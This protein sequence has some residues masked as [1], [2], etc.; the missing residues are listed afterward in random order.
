MNKN[1]DNKKNS[2]KE[3]PLSEDKSQN[4]Q[5]K[6]VIA[7]EKSVKKNNDSNAANSKKQ[8]S[9]RDKS[10]SMPSK[11]EKVKLEKHKPAAENSLKND[12][13]QVE[14]KKVEG[15][16]SDTPKNNKKKPTK[17]KGSKNTDTVLAESN[18][19]SLARTEQLK[20]QFAQNP[21]AALTQINR[22]LQNENSSTGIVNVQKVANQALAENKIVL[23]NRFVLESVL[24][25]GGMGTVYKARDLRK[26]EAQ[27]SNPYVAAKI[28]NSDFR[29]HPDAFVSLQREASRSHILSH[30]NIVTVH[31]F[32]RDGNTIFM[33][34]ELLQ[35][36][37]LDLL[38]LQHK[39]V[40]L[41]QEQA[42]KILKD[43][44]LALE[45]AHKKGIIH[46]DL[47]PANIYV[48]PDGTKVLDF[49]IARI[50][51]DSRYQDHFDAGSIG[52][53]TPSYASLEMLHEQEPDKSDD[54][55][56]A[57]VIAYELLTGAHPYGGKSAATAL[58]LNLK[59]E[60][61]IGL[62]KLQ[63]KALSS[64]LELRRENRLADISEFIQAMTVK[65]KL[66]VF[67][68]A[69]VVLFLVLIV[70][71]YMQFLMPDE[72]SVYVDDMLQRANKCHQEEDYFCE[73][74]SAKAI[75]GAVPEHSEAA[76]I[77]AR[78]EKDL[79]NFRL[80]NEISQALI[81]A[82]ECFAQSD[83]ECALE[84]AK[85]ILQRDSNHEAALNLQSLVSATIENNK[86]QLAQQTQ[87]FNESM[88]KANEC[89]NQRN[90]DCA[91]E[92]AQQ[93]LIYKPDNATAESLIQSATY[94]NQQT[95]QN[96]QKAQKVLQ[97][98]LKCF[99]KL[100]YSC[101]I[102]K[103]ESALEFIPGYREALKLKRDAQKA[104]ESV[105]GTI[106]I[107]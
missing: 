104:M 78:A 36:E 3:T 70:V 56:A 58:A 51:S 95:Q 83:Y 44:G 1:N 49:G 30:P 61:I 102:A 89:F 13:H 41:P 43:F 54:V 96:K 79:A 93:A 27:D 81:K 4:E 47:K 15:G 20:K 90:Y 92:Q 97:D 66:P 10:Q 48:T 35:G 67:K 69:S 106:E 26:V 73:V 19:F 63:W 72:L 45:Y 91:I 68:V 12:N 21:E 39:N 11:P 76:E 32:D 33:T 28:L 87:A 37:A 71:G 55:Y 100:D 107:Q 85:Q 50:A 74:A 77:L 82:Q 29:N 59:P 84:A 34:M 60:K 31:D 52:A 103:S 16:S 17:N 94:A 23:N 2:P 101:A 99:K 64:G 6:T 5:R 75:L 22:K 88:D 86:L 9:K 98:G 57:A 18:K 42:L 38:L 80:Q 65:P 8:G 25:A 7:P 40:G 53:L 46:S 24:G 62:S 105:K 14:A